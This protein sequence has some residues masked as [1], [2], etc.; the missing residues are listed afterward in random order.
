MS[1]ST[2]SSDNLSKYQ[3]LYEKVY[4]GCAMFVRDV[5]LSPQLTEK[6]TAGSILREKAFTDASIRFMGMVTTHRY[7]ILSNHMANLSAFEHGTNWGLH[8]ANKDSHFKVLG[9]HSC[10]GKTGI[11]LLHLP[12]D[13]SWKAWQTVVFDLDE[14]LYRMATERFDAKCSAPPVPELTTPQW[15]DRCSFP[16]GMDNAGNFW[17]LEDAA[18]PPS[19]ACAPYGPYHSLQER[20]RGCLLGGAVG[21]ALGYP[22]EFIKEK[23]IWDKYGPCGIQTLEQAGTPALISDD[24]QM[25]LFAA[26]AILYS[27]G[28]KLALRPALWLAYREWLGTQGDTSRMDSPS[29][30]KMWIFRDPRLH[31]C[32][33]PGNTCLDAIRHSP[34]GGTPDSPVNNSKGCGTVMRAAPLGLAISSSDKGGLKTVYDM[35]VADAALT[36]GHRLAWASSGALAQII[37]EI[38][39]HRPQRDYLLQE[40]VAVV[41]C[42]GSD[43]L[44]ALLDKAVQLAEDSSVDDL[45]A[46]HMLGEG[47]VA[48]EALA[49]AVFCAVRHQNDFAAAI[50]AAVNHKGDSDSTGAICGNILGAWLGEDA[51]AQAFDL[52]H[53]E[54]R[55]VIEKMA[56]RLFTAVNGPFLRRHGVPFLD[57]PEG[58]TEQDHELWQQMQPVLLEKNLPGPMAAGEFVSAFLALFEQ[59][60]GHSLSRADIPVSGTSGPTSPTCY[61]GVWWADHLLPSL[62]RWIAEADKLPC[63]V[64]LPLDGFVWKLPAAFAQALRQ[65]PGSEEETVAPP[66]PK[67]T[68]ADPVVPASAEYD[69]AAAAPDGAKPAPVEEAASADAAMETN[70]T[71]FSVTEDH[72]TE[73]VVSSL[74]EETDGVTGSEEASVSDARPT[75]IPEEAPLPE[76]VPTAEPAAQENS[77]PVPQKDAVPSA[78]SAPEAKS[79]QE[80]P[81]PSALQEVPENA[82]APQVPQ[83]PPMVPLRPV[84]LMYTPLTKKALAICFDAHKNQCDKG[85]LPYV[86]HPF[87]LAEQMETELEVCTALLHDVVEDS[88]YTFEDLRREGFPQPVLEALR[89]MT[90]DPYMHYLDYVVQLRR[91]PIARRVKLADLRHNSDLNRLV[92]VG[93]KDKRRLLRYRMALAILAADDY[94]AGRRCFCKRL[95]LSVEQPVFLTVY[96]DAAGKVLYYCVS[97]DAAAPSCCWFDAETGEKLRITLHPHRTLPDSL[98]DLTPLSCQNLDGLLRH[99]GVDPTRDPAE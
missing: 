24:T 68:P 19:P 36:H 18:V 73:E 57:C 44:K 28:Q 65:I 43:D 49:I 29:G 42:P 8:V 86:F 34:D 3:E 75:G 88:H 40:A 95:P 94:D 92:A 45:D 25:T 14:K 61:S 56:D 11:F 58:G 78:A 37:Y 60:T 7:V 90:R 38:V 39:Q 41:F 53:L 98:A 9:V 47:W 93:P 35:A 2:V 67:P 82:A 52:D 16:V 97:E 6:Y 77:L 59:Q 12:N 69:P 54:L 13:E 79:V 91:N 31:A 66:A 85:G 83:N 20:Y 71:E 72:S 17:P 51:V 99:Y 26:N 4:P 48:E 5:N 1:T 96:Y 63:D 62:C 64:S 15:L 33:A 89:L 32:R 81:L 22:V 74:P 50:R 46:I 87:H 80:V 84:G 10:G 76:T 23:A 30:P 21:D 55:D 70:D 27:R